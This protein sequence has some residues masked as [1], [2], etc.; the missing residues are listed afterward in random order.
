MQCNAHDELIGRLSGKGEYRLNSHP[1][2][3]QSS[4]E[5]LIAD[6]QITASE[7]VCSSVYSS[8]SH[9]VAAADRGAVPACL[10]WQSSSGKVRGTTSSAHPDF[11]AESLHANEHSLYTYTCCI[12]KTP[13][14]RR[15]VTARCYAER[16]YATASCPSVR[17]FVCPSVTVMYHDHIGLEYFENNF[18]LDSKGNNAKF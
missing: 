7:S 18:T 12:A 11:S 9:W 8:Q 4:A 3:L 6:R 16:S 1:W 2:L 5:L 13:L 17:L 10:Q 14:L 15:F